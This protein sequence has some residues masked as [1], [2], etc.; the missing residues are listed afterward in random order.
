MTICIGYFADEGLRSAVGYLKHMHKEGPDFAAEI[1]V[2]RGSGEGNTFPSRDDWAEST[3]GEF[4]NDA[5]YSLYRIIDKHS[6]KIH[7]FLSLRWDSIPKDLEFEDLLFGQGLEK[8]SKSLDIPKR[9]FT[10]DNLHAV[11]LQEPDEINS[12]PAQENHRRSYSNVPFDQRFKYLEEPPVDIE[13]E[14]V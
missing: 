7:T 6:G 2:I 5:G 14:S 4:F 12:I 10:R 3:G 1:D 8:V 13:Q 9:Y 11:L